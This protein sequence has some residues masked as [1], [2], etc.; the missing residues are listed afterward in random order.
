MSPRLE[1]ICDGH[2][3]A[4]TAK[5]V[6]DGQ[7]IQNAL[8]GVTLT[9]GMHEVT[10]HLDLAVT[11]FT[12]FEGSDVQIQIRDEVRDLLIRHG[13]TPPDESDPA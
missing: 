2:I 9:M 5:V 7:E 13:W 12:R 10:A 11:E 8:R 4:G 1:I 3:P 6:L